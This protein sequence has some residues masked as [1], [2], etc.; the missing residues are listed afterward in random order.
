MEM[1]CNRFSGCCMFIAS[2]TAYSFAMEINAITPHGI[3]CTGRTNSYW[4]FNFKVKYY[5]LVK[6][7]HKIFRTESLCFIIIG[8]LIQCMAQR[9]SITCTS[10]AVS[11]SQR[12]N[13]SVRGN[14]LKWSYA[15]FCWDTSTFDL[16]YWI[17]LGTGKMSVNLK[18]R[19]QINRVS[20]YF[21]WHKT[22]NFLHLFYHFR[23]CKPLD[24]VR[25]VFYF[26]SI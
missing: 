21:H 18:G 9:W 14:A 15:W 17:I 25:L 8:V 24:F 2:L 16:I 20:T 23:L 12:S 5:D 19:F 10:R 1:L 4:V 7:I 26:L 3:I 13:Y 6:I 11:S 22:W